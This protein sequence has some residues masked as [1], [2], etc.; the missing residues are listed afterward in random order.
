MSSKENCLHPSSSNFPMVLC[1]KVQKKGQ[2]HSNGISIINAVN[3]IRN[4][5]DFS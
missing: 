3:P 2:N 4:L 5:N 1:P